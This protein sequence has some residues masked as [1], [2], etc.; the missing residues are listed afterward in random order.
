[1]LDY[2]LLYKKAVIKK[3]DPE[4]NTTILCKDLLS[5][6]FNKSI[7]TLSGSSFVVNEHYVARPDLV[8]LAVYNEDK[9]GDVICKINGISNPFEL[10]EDTILFCPSPAVLHKI[11]NQASPSDLSLPVINI[12]SNKAKDLYNDNALLNGGSSSAKQRVSVD[13]IGVDNA[14]HK[15]KLNERRSPGDQTIIDSNYV[16]DKSLG[17]VIY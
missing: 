2:G 11:F 4:T 8:S 15:K 12:G 13:R 14:I 6:T 7:G 10:S 9:Y 17:V 16:I 3:R 1:M 5:E